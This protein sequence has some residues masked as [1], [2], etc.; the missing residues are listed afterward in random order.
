MDKWY[1]LLGAGL[2]IFSLLPAALITFTGALAI[3]M[4][5]GTA[6]GAAVIAAGVCLIGLIIFAKVRDANDRQ[7]MKK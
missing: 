7:A 1:V 3:G 4:N 6:T 5:A 2:C